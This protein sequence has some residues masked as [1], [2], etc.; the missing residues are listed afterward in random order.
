MASYSD[1]SHFWTIGAIEQTQ[2]L[3]LAGPSMMSAQQAIQSQAKADMTA[4]LAHK[5]SDVRSDLS[6]RLSEAKADFRSR[7]RKD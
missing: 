4:L 7:L 2:G 1:P 3:S 5:R 6:S